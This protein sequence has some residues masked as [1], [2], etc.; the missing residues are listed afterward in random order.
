MTGKWEEYLAFAQ[1][2]QGGPGYPSFFD[3]LPL[4]SHLTLEGGEEYAELTLVFPQQ[5]QRGELVGETFKKEEHWGERED[6][7]MHVR[8]STRRQTTYGER[9][10][11][12]IVSQ[13]RR[14]GV[15]VKDLPSLLQQGVGEALRALVS[16]DAYEP[17]SANAKTEGRI[18]GWVKS[19]FLTPRQAAQLRH[20]REMA[21]A[22]G[23]PQD[24]QYEELAGEGTLASLAGAQRAAGAISRR[25]IRGDDH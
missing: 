9:E 21:Y 12:D 16:K 5:Q 17:P 3:D 8:M 22:A 24:L 15:K 23:G 4:F 10:L 6:V 18:D 13:L 7:L 2:G 11:Q 20:A 25:S 1:G 19:G 14:G